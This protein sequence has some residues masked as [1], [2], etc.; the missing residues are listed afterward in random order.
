LLSPDARE[1]LRQQQ[2]FRHPRAN[3]SNNQ[4][5][6][7]FVDNTAKKTG[8]AKSTISQDAMRG[9]KAKVAKSATFAEETAKRTGKSARKV[10]VD[11]TRG[12]NQNAKIA[13]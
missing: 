5:R 9:K 8:K 6:S 7:S 2:L 11:V 13:T 1:Q 4:S 12:E 3:N 10:R